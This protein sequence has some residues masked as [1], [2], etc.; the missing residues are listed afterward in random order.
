MN[1]LLE[2][3]EKF[4][5]ALAEPGVTFFDLYISYTFLRR[6]LNFDGNDR[7]SSKKVGLPPAQR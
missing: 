2:V 1:K 7:I 3:N 4:A 6:N 5:F